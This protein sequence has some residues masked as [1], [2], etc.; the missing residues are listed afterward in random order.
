MR[1]F[2]D[3]GFRDTSMEE[4][5]AAVDMQPSGLYRYFPSKA[6]MLIA[7]S[8]V[9]PTAYL[10]TWPRSSPATPTPRTPSPH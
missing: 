1:L 9:P 3:R 8:V 10:E 5:A 4:I 2:Y 7:A 6:D